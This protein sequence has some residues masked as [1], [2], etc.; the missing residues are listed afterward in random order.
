MALGLFL[1]WTGSPLPEQ[2]QPFQGPVR[3]GL[4]YSR[5]G[6]WME[7]VMYMTYVLIPETIFQPWTFEQQVAA[8]LFRLVWCFKS[9]YQIWFDHSYVSFKAHTNNVALGIFLQINNQINN[10]LGFSIHSKGQLRRC[11]QS[12]SHKPRQLVHCLYMV[13]LAILADILWHRS[14]TVKNKTSL[15]FW[16][17]LHHCQSVQQSDWQTW[18]SVWGCC[19]CVCTCGSWLLYVLYVT[20]IVNK[21]ILHISS[22][23]NWDN[24]LPLL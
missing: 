16:M 8:L 21:F 22:I 10:V 6:P 5:N 12:D 18:W 4:G 11:S 1:E 9:G 23:I 2:L 14:S 13:L 15:I 20:A 24:C 7:G 17:A 19:V 3:L